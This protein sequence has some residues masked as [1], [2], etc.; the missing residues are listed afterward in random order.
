MQRVGTG[1]TTSALILAFGALGAPALA[2]TETIRGQ[3]IDKACYE[4]DKRNTSLKHLNRPVD[5][6][7]MVCAKAGLPLA[8]LTSDGK[9]YLIVGE[10]AKE[11]NA[12]LAM[13]MTHTV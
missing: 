11:K 12:K 8:L 13:H 2:K 4:R 6:C 10:L 7:G 3:L 1:M 9:V 5:E